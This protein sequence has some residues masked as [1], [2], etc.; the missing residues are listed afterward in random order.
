MGGFRPP[1][2]PRAYAT[3]PG[4]HV[5]LIRPCRDPRDAAQ[6]HPRKFNR[7]TWKQ[8]QLLLSQSGLVLCIAPPPFSRDRRI[9]MKNSSSSINQSYQVLI[10][11]LSSYIY[12]PPYPYMQSLLAIRIAYIGTMHYA[13]TISLRE[14]AFFSLC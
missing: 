9:K 12:V 8:R 13:K 7:K 10:G 3:G 2:P 6:A 14:F 4:P 1:K 5:L 11:H